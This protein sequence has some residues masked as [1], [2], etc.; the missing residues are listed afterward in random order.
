MIYNVHGDLV[1]AEDVLVPPKSRD[2]DVT[3]TLRLIKIA[4][5]HDASFSIQFH[6]LFQISIIHIFKYGVGRK[7]LYSSRSKARLPMNVT[8]MVYVY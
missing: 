3:Q 5:H 7:Q 2:L 6:D 8:P 4:F 1:S